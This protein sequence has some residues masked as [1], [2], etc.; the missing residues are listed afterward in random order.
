[1][2]SVAPSVRALELIEVKIKNVIKCSHGRPM[3]MTLVSFFP[4]FYSLPIYNF[5]FFIFQ[6]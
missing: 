1:M 2:G 6:F 5:R 3:T 4:K